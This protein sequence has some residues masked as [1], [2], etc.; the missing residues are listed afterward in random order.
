LG[1][2]ESPQARDCCRSG[3]ELQWPVSELAAPGSAV[4]PWYLNL[5]PTPT[6][7]S[8]KSGSNNHP[9]WEGADRPA[10]WTN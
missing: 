5:N 10:L 1:G 6:D 7:I 4:K 3:A 9:V 2:E 8:D